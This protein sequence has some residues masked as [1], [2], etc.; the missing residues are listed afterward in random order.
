M[1]T[2]FSGLKACHKPT[3]FCRNPLIFIENIW[4]LLCKTYMKE[5]RYEKL[6][7]IFNRTDTFFLWTGPAQNGALSS[8]DGVYASIGSFN[9]LNLGHRKEKDYRRIAKLIERGE[10]DVLAVQEVKKEEGLTTLLEALNRYTDTSWNYELSDYRNGESTQGSEYFA[11]FYNENTTS[12]ITYGK[13]YCDSRRAQDT[14][15][16]NPASCFVKDS[17][18][19]EDATWKRDP[20]IAHFKIHGEKFAFATA[21]SHYGSNTKDHYKIRHKEILGLKKLMMSMRRLLDDYTV[22]GLGDFNLKK[23]KD[24]ILSLRERSLHYIPDEFFTNAIDTVSGEATTVGGNNYDHI[25]YFKTEDILPAKTSFEV[26]VDFDREDKE[27][28]EEFKT[29]VS[30]HF[31]IKV[32]FKIK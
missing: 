9:A 19:P 24:N 28:K 22:I 4:P 30:D 32:D 1:N 7:I 13:N 25:V 17:D 14:E 23:H 10:F 31:P 8:T 20:F 18:N 27:E 16:T 21:H 5:G 6:R 2:A 15:S 29:E 3:F 11:Y 26:L 12:P